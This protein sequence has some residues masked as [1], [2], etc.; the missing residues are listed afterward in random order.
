MPVGWYWSGYIQQAWNSTCFG[1]STLQGAERG[2][3]QVNMCSSTG[4]HTSMP[5]QAASEYTIQ[6][7]TRQL[8]RVPNLRKVPM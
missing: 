8:T 6:Q 3:G 1:D 5:G 7:A 2:E 4:D